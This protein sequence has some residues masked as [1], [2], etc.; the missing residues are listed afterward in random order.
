MVENIENDA[1]LRAHSLGVMFLEQLE[2]AVASGGMDE[3]DS[4]LWGAKE[5]AVSLWIK[6]SSNLLKLGEHIPATPLA[7]SNSAD[8][9]AEDRLILERYISSR[10][11]EQNS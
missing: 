8:M 9:L 7:E 10:H 6:I 5:N 2:K 3:S 11:Y 1:L 4:W